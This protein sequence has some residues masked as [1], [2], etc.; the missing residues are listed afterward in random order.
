MVKMYKLTTQEY[1]TYGGML[2]KIGKTNKALG[3]GTQMCT[4]QVLHCYASPSRPPHRRG[5]AGLLPD[6]SKKL[7]TIIDWVLENID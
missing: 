1:T 6:F 3:K 5:R 7:V 2:W 4:N